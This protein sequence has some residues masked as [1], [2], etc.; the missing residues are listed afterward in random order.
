MRLVD[1]IRHWCRAMFRERDLEQQV[2]EEL[3]AWLAELTERHHRQGLS[4]TEARARALADVGNLDA[5][6]ETVRD[7]R[8][9]AT[10]KDVRP[11]IRFAWRSLRR[12]PGLTAAVVLTF[13]LGIGANTAI[14]SV[15]NAMLIAPLPY[16]DASRLVVIW[17]DMTD[18]GYPRAPLSSPELN[19]LRAQTTL[20]DGIGAIWATTGTLTGD[21]EPEQLRTGLVTTNFFS[22]LGASP[23]LGR[24]FG[25]EDELQTASSGIVLSWATFERRFGANRELIGQRI[26]VN[27]RPTTVVGVMPR[28][29]RLLLPTDA[30]VPDD[31]QAWSFAKSAPFASQPRGQQFFRVIGRMKAG[32]TV[33]QA[34]QDVANVARAISAAFSEYGSAGRIFKTYALQSDDVREVRG[35]L[36]MLAGGVAI[37]LLIACVNV[38]GLLVARAAGR[39]RETAV[40]IALGAGR[41]RLLRQYLAEGLLIAIMGAIAGL[42]GGWA[43]LHGL[44]AWRPAS[45]ARID[46]AHIDLTVLSVTAVITIGW[47]VLL[48][49][50]P[51][52]ETFR[53]NVLEV[54]QRGSQRAGNAMAVRT[55]TTLVIVQVA[56]SAVLL[57]GAGLLVHTF[58]NIQR[59]DLGIRGDGAFTFRV[60]VPF[61]RYQGGE[62]INQFGRNLLERL[63]ALP[64]VTGAGAISHLPFDDLPNWGGGYIVK[65]GADLRSVPVADYRAVSPGFFE[66]AGA[67]LIAGRFITDEDERGHPLSIVVDDILARRAW[68]GE[69]AIG[70]T[71]IVDPGSNGSP[72]APAQVVGVVAHLRLRSVIEDLAEQVYFP[73]RQVLRNP[74]AYVVRTTADPA[75]LAGVFRQTVASIDP[76]VPIF[77]PRPFS[78]YVDQARS[79]NRF[80][81]LLAASFAA[82]ALLLSA[83][84]VY[85]V[86]AYTI[87]ERRREFGVRLALG[88][89]SA[90]IAMLVLRRGALLAGVGLV[91]GG[92]AA[93]IAAYALR[94]QLFE[95][96]PLDPMSYG[97]AALALLVV[98]ASA[99]WIPARR[100]TSASPL[101]VLRRD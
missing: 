24:T 91:C 10:L 89:E 12:T 30:S 17:S 3:Q 57:V 52:S 45:L 94:G 15:V 37:L 96:T 25:P 49:L 68:P 32:V 18:A 56:L 41:Q 26:M 29:F 35:A 27:N 62:A 97:A 84:G 31:L 39:R 88:A 92:A 61:A 72:T 100:A 82:V 73:V 80:M 59:R 78:T 22:V 11:D 87:T 101:D 4:I 28:D 40:C 21:G 67:R 77:D 58:V 47:G 44:L 7:D 60:A 70:K 46:R 79:G 19:D 8:P 34:R 38:A 1:R 76:A 23:A 98:A 53:T 51:L 86:I 16:H 69:S 85:G 5:V 65:P 74:M 20:F 75:S 99:T 83:V 63:R 81:A 2:D 43:A 90:Q 42:A 71:L 95:V 55:R 64:G 50:A 36:L 6:K 9:G 48:S 93:A 54:L 66:A 33:E 14:F 13:A